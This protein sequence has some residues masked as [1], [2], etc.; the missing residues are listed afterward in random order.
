MA[1]STPATSMPAAPRRVA[2]AAPS[3]GSLMNS[4][5]QLTLIF[6][7]WPSAELAQEAQ[8]VVVVH[9]D[10]ID[11]VAQHAQALHT[12]AEGPAA[13]AFRIYTAGFE[14]VGVYHP[15]TQHLQPAGLLAHAAAL[16][17]AEEAA[18]VHFRARL[19]EREEGG[20]ET[21]LEVVLLEEALHEIREGAAQVRHAHALVHQ[22]ALHLVEH[23]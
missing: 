15:A 12:H 20:A 14:H 19:H 17:A 6:M 4:L 8:V 1:G 16:A 2:M 23:G 21:Q 13:V 18:D 7:T 10:V 5:S 9:A 11:A 3:A 22:E